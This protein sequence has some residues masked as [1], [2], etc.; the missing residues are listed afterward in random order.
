MQIAILLNAKI[1]PLTQIMRKTVINGSNTSG[2]QRT[3]LIARDGYVETEQGK[4]GIES[5]CIEED[6][7]RIVERKKDEIVYIVPKGDN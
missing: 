6:S 4:V 1:F 3:V 2:F 7:A 5:V